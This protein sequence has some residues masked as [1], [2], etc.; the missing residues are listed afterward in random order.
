MKI[1][2]L[3]NFKKRIKNLTPLDLGRSCIL[4]PVLC[5][6]DAKAIKQKPVNTLSQNF[7]QM[8]TSLLVHP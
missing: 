3:P 1:Y 7:A 6:F 8:F 2:H 5:Q 4:W